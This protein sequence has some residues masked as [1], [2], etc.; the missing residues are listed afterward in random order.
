MGSQVRAVELCVSRTMCSPDWLQLRGVVN[1]QAAKHQAAAALLP[2]LGRD[3]VEQ[4]AVVDLAQRLA[5]DDAVGRPDEQ[6]RREALEEGG[7]P[8]D[9]VSDHAILGDHASRSARQR[10]RT[11]CAN[12]RHVRPPLLPSS[13]L[14]N[15]GVSCAGQEEPTI[16][17]NFEG[18]N[19][20]SASYVPVSE[21]CLQRLMRCR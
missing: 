13:N 14:V 8:A 5:R 10:R 15:C 1:A 16:A 19:R 18:T 12:S 21:P 20:P 17:S 11:H 2:P 3:V 7:R 9:R 4:R 6:E